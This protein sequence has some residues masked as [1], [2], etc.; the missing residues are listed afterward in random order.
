CI[1]AIAEV[2]NN[3]GYDEYNKQNFSSAINFYT[4]GIKV[5]CKDKELNAKLYSNRA[6]AHLDLGNYT[7]VLNDSK[8][9]IDLL[10]YFFKACVPGAGACVRLKKFKEAIRWCHKGLVFDPIN[11]DLLE[12]RDWSVREEKKL[13]DNQGKEVKSYGKHS[14]AH[15]NLGAIDYHKRYLKTMKELGD[16]SEEGLAYCL[17]GS[18]YWSMGDFRTA[19]GCHGRH[20]QITKEL[21]DRSGESV[22]YIDLAR[23]HESLEDF[24]TAVCYHERYLKIAKEL[25]DRSGERDAYSSLGD[26]HR[27]LGSFKTAIDFYERHLNIAKELGD[28]SEEGTAYGNLG[29]A[30]HSLRDFETAINYFDRHLK[31]AKEL[32]DRLRE[33][34]AYGNLGNTYRTLGDYKTA[35]SYL[36]HYLNISKELGDRSGEGG[37]YSN[38]GCAHHLLGDF[39][40]ALDYHERDLKIATEMGDRS[41]EGLAYCNLGCNHQSL[42]D[43][44]TA[45]DYHQ[46]HLKIAKELGDRCGKGTA[47]GNLGIIYRSLGDFKTAIDYHERQLKIAKEL[48]DKS[49]EGFAYSNLGSDH[50]RLGDFG[51]AIDYH[52]SHLKIAKKLGDSSGK[53]KAY[54]NL[55]SA[56][57]SLGDLEKAIHYYELSLKVAKELGDRSVEGKAYGSLGNAHRELQ[58]F[59]TAIDYDKRSLK[60]CKE[61]GDISGEGMAYHNLG[62]TYSHLGDFERAIDYLERDLKISKELGDKLGEGTTYTS[63]GTC[64]KYKGQVPVAIG[65]Y[66]LSISSFKKVRDRLPLN[67]EWKI[68][69]R[70]QYQ[71]AYTALWRLLLAEGKIIEALISADR[72]RAQ[73]LKDL[74]ALN[75]GLEVKD[76]E[77]DEGDMIT[78]FELSSH[79]PTNTIF[80]A[81]GE[82]ELIFWVCQEGTALEL[83]INPVDS[84]GEISSFF[85]SLVELVCQEI[86]ARD[87]VECEDRSLK[88]LNDKRHERLAVQRS[89]LDG[90]Q[91]QNLHN[92]LNTLSDVI[93]DPIQDLF[94]GSEILFVPEGPLCLAPFAALKGP[95]SKYLSESFRIR[96]APSLTSLKIIADCPVDYHVTSGAL[97]VGD[98]WVQDVTKLPRLPHAREEVEM[99]GRILGCTPLIGRQATKDEVLRRLGSVALV[100]IAAHGSMKAGEIALAPN[101][102]EKDFM[103]TLKDVLR[104]QMRARLVVL[105]CCHSAQGEI[106]AEGVVGIARAFLGAG[107]RSVLVSLWAVDDKATL[108]F[109]KHFYQHLVKGKSAGEALHQAMS[110][111]R[112]SEEFG[113]VKYWAPFV[114]IGDDVTLEFA[115]C[116]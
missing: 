84:K 107:A 77:S 17:L 45:I 30:H 4:E 70:D 7:E 23:V 56:H 34:E 29:D 104:V 78:F 38:L 90:S 36:E 105:S 69:L 3:E 53:E 116:E 79:F 91:F 32:G 96:I 5:N 39:K 71:T 48:G 111:M 94:L 12:L 99:I 22:A 67:D 86:G 11:H 66:Q 57:Q 95:N 8:I 16:R 43:F 83:R 20:L 97:L 44:K 28:K 58:D 24:K 93:I 9:A 64:F 63:L 1:I 92:S 13:K 46:S 106:K 68:N 100:H 110:C 114:L 2:Y 14:S 41:A 55:G 35:I 50:D 37:A 89:T 60:V 54:G 113:A 51:A 40:T 26:A 88:L 73:G 33:R 49:G 87:Y 15:R 47:Y 103:L 76:A 21:G 81:L 27:G 72:G 108:E 61:L 19:I 42:G 59:E 31:I 62:A 10:P 80:M 18:A 52:K 101:N 98:P 82:N 102:R 85:E 75:Y 65:Y 115:L 6:T 25:G 74:M 112:E 109:M